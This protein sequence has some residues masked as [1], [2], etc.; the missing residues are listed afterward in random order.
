MTNCLA[1]IAKVPQDNFSIVNELM[2]TVHGYTNDQKLLDAPHKGPRRAQAATMSIY[3]L[4]PGLPARLGFVPG[5]KGKPH[6]FTVRVT[7]PNVSLVDLSALL[8]R[9][10]GELLILGKSVIRH[11]QAQIPSRRQTSSVLRGCVAT[12]AGVAGSLKRP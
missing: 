4:R 11:T 9:V 3:R 1:P 7:T 10:C 12:L 5:L 6:G 8:E 2:A